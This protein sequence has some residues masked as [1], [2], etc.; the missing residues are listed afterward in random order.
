MALRKGSEEKKGSPFDL[1]DQVHHLHGAQGAVVA[2]VACLGA[3][4]LDGLL[5]GVG[6]ED[7]KHHGDVTLQGDMGHA[8]GDLGADVVIVAGAA[9]D[10]SPQAD[11]RVVL[12]ALGHLGGDEGDLESAGDPGH[13]DILLVDTMADQAVHGAPQELRGD[14]FIE[15]GGH[16]ADLHVIG[17][18]AAFKR[19]HGDVPPC[20][21][22]K[23]R[24]Q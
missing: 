14:E 11:D 20:Y 7:A 10:D 16:D 4:P 3:G 8:L 1:A 2:L 24:D 12:A 9:P 5:N 6:G 22:I 13:L 18:H 19:F 21:V 15:P 23:I 17:Y